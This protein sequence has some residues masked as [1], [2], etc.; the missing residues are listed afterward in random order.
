MNV[1]HE[2]RFSAFLHASGTDRH[3]HFLMLSIHVIRGRPLLL[4]PFTIPVIISFSKE[5]FCLIMCPK[6]CSFLR[7]TVIKNSLSEPTS[8]KT[9]SL[10]FFAV[11]GILSILR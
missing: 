10:V 2:A 9:S 11:Q 4:E 5:F 8:F 7:F 6:Y 1:L 3:V